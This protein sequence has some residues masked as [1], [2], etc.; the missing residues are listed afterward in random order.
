M[1]EVGKLYVVATPIGNLE[2]ITLR[3]ITV[4][5]RVHLIAAEDTRQSKKLLNHYGIDT[6]LY[7]L[8][9]HNERTHSTK[10]IEQL[11]SGHDVAY[12]TDAGTPLISDPGAYL[13]R[14]V[15]QEGLTIVPIPGPSALITALSA[16]GFSTPHFYFGGF[17]PSKQSSR[18]QALVDLKFLTCSL[19]F[20]ES[21]H[22]ILDALTDILEVLGNRELVIARELT[23][24]YE[25]IKSGSVAAVFD[26]LMTSSEQRLG[27]F[28]V[29]VAGNAEEKITDA[30]AIDS[31]LEIMLPELPIKQA[32]MLVSKIMGASKNEVYAA[33][34]ELK[35]SPKFREN[36]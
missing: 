34:L 22:R 21:P 3:A 15:R 20:Y 25:T 19:V 33:A 5:K 11:K 36:E 23:K 1:Q 35:K 12:V 16:S 32:A 14:L 7:S 29:L 13:V 18:K 2:D 30:R 24:K 28:V 27:E 9:A 10:I 31:M 17:L 26:F 4:L 6:P 8:H